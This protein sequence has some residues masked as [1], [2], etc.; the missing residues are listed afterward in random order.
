GAPA[1]RAALARVRYAR[2]LAVPRGP[3]AATRANSLGL[4]ARES[5]VLALVA[6]GLT[7][8]EIGQRLFLSAKTVGHHVSALLR[9]TGAPSRARAVAAARRAGLLGGPT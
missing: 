1:V 4:T 7:N 8:A 2:G 5:E 6:D 3:R 9:K